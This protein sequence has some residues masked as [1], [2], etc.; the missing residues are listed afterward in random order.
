MNEINYALT[1]VGIEITFSI[2]VLMALRNVGAKGSTLAIIGLV[3]SLWLT[4][5]YLLLANGFFSATGLPQVAFALGLAIPISIGVLAILLWPALS[6]AVNSMSTH[7]FL[8]L[9]HMRALFG[10]MFFFTTALPA[11]VQYI[12]GLGDIASGIGAFLALRH[13][14]NHPDEERLAIIRGNIVGILD[15]LI[16][17]NLG[18]FVWMRDNSPDI[19][20]SLIPLYVVPTFIILHIFSLLRLDQVRQDTKRI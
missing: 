17:L 16:I 18:V 14:R 9:Q 7:T 6:D 11:W 5:D 20:F 19:P 10:V 1:L 2:M 12:G 3:Y 4:G 13:F 15:L 8:L